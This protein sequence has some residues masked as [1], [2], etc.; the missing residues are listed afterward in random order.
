MFLSNILY[1]SC[2]ILTHPNSKW[3]TVGFLCNGS[4]NLGFR[5]FTKGIV[6]IPFTQ[7]HDIYLFTYL[8]V[9][10]KYTIYMPGIFFKVQN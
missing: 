5:K 4:S 8:F 6:K 9:S 1:T 10:I 3:L 7:I 2:K